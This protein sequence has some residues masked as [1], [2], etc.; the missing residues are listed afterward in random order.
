MPAESVLKS[1]LIVH[2][3]SHSMQNAMEFRLAFKLKVVKCVTVHMCDMIRIY[4]PTYC[5]HSRSAMRNSLCP[6]FVFTLELLCISCIRGYYSRIY[7]SMKAPLL[8]DH[9]LS[10]LLRVGEKNSRKY[11]ISVVSYA[12]KLCP[13]YSAHTCTR[14]ITRRMQSTEGRA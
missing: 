6:C 4:M 1:L 2:P 12:S 3:V 13:S 5:I 7:G 9:S 8:Q 14:I 10:H 11:S